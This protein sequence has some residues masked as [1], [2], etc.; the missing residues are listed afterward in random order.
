MFNAKEH[1]EE[2]FNLVKGIVENSKVDD[3]IKEMLFEQLDEA[4]E[5][6]MDPFEVDIESEPEFKVRMYTLHVVIST[7]EALQ[8][9]Y[10]VSRMMDELFE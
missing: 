8:R 3:D 5:E 4:K 9:G 2:R 1:I 10:E 7:C 6:I